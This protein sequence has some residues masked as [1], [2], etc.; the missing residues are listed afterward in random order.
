MALLFHYRSLL[1]RQKGMN[2][3]KK[4][5]NKQI[6]EQEREGGMDYTMN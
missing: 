6:E 1:T 3:R 5:G 2:E 4:G